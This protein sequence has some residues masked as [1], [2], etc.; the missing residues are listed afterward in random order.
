[1]D[2][3]DRPLLSGLR[4]P[5]TVGTPGPACCALS[6]RCSAV[7][8]AGMF[9]SLTVILRFSPC[10]WSAAGAV[11]GGLLTGPRQ[12]ARGPPPGRSAAAWPVR[13][14]RPPGRSPAEL[15]HVLANANETSS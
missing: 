3:L 8:S 14:R 6:H 13:R 12:P 4:T 7:V 2:V 9:R 1:T 10:D 11:I 15:K 5:V